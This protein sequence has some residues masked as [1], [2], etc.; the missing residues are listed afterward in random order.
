[1]EIRIKSLSKNYF[2]G[3]KTIRALAEVD[4]RIPANQIFT[5]LGP[6]GCGKTTLLRC[7][8]GLE[9]P[10]AG[11]I[12][13][14]EEIV[15]SGERRISVPTENR[16]LGM[17]FQTYAIWPHMTVF[18]NV[19]YPLQTRREPKA[20]IRRKVKN[21]LRLVQLEGFENR[22]ATNLSGGQQQR[23]AL[24]RAL[25]AEPK[26]ILF[27]EAA[28]QPRRQAARRDAQGAAQL[29]DRAQD[30]GRL[31]DP[32]PDRSPRP[33]GHG[34]GDGG[35]P[36][37]G[38]RG[39]PQDLLRIRPSLRGRF[40]R[41]R[42]PGRRAGEDAGRHL[43]DRRFGHRHRRLPQKARFG[44]RQRGGR[45]ASAPSFLTVLGADA[46]SR[47]NLFRGII[48]SLVFV[49]EAYEGEIRIG[50]TRLFTRIEPSA[51]LREGDRVAVAVDPAHCFLL[52][53]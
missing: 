46:D 48:D 25:V 43:G 11:E 14:G 15:W 35:R 39:A 16:G 50:D 2:S 3:G 23:V 4:L 53:K 42:Q 51:T 30:H 38:D 36:H 26:V 24:A 47:P 8:V 29:S 7:I 6:S 9:T 34:G 37:R 45:S 19:A 28:E 5:L 17:V 41:S 32:R 1:M 40:H 27:D 21:T 10:D 12:A 31:C 22:P 49:G 18:D 33:V 52:S 44:P 13:I 20:E